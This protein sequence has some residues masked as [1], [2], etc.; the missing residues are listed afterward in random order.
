MGKE[1]AFVCSCHDPVKGDRPSTTHLASTAL[2]RIEV[3]LARDASDDFA[4]LR[5]SEAL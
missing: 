1:P 3:V 2:L 4:V 5:H